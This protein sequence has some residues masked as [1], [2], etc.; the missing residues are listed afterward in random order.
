M[1]LHT[2]YYQL[3][4]KNAA[5]RWIKSGSIEVIRMIYSAVRDHNWETIEPHIMDEKIVQNDNGFEIWTCVKYHH[6]NIHFLAEYIITGKDNMLE[7]ELNGQ[8]QSSFTTCR[9]GFCVLHPLKECSGKRCKVIHPDNSIETILFPK[10]ISANQPM[11]NISGMKWEPGCNTTARLDFEGEIFE[12]ED[13]RNW[14]DASYK[15]YCR[16]LNLPFPYD[17]LKGENI[18]QK[19]VLKIAGN[20]QLKQ[21][22]PKFITFNI[23]KNRIFKIPEFGI[24]NASREEPLTAF[25]SLLLKKIPLS[26]LRCEIKLYETNWNLSLASAITNADRL[27]LPFFFVLYHSK[28]WKAELSIFFK[29]SRDIFLKVSHILIVGE[30]HMTDYSVFEAA[31]P[32]LKNRFPSAKIGTGVNAYFAELNRDRQFSTKPDFVNFT[33]SP[34]VHAFDNDSLVENLEGQKFVVE[35]AKLYFPGKSIYVSPVTLKQ[36]FN[37]VATEEE[38][39]LQAKDL[40]QQVDFRQS[41]VFAAK[42]LIGSIKFLSQAGADLITYFE[43]VGWKGFIQGDFN[44]PLPKKFPG[45]IGDVFPV[46]TIFKEICGFDKIIFSECNS[47]L[48]IDGLVLLNKNKIKAILSN[49]TDS[50]KTVAFKG[51]TFKT[52][53]TFLSGKISSINNELEIPAKELVILRN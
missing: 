51:V 13:Q 15:T 34:Q 35:S 30:N 44:P 23:D 5:V 50:P 6:N 33:I 12:M 24:C 25:E 53:E 32:M 18:H 17:I 4:Y 42:W 52:C 38:P 49:F 31:Y 9:I 11:L 8:A 37:V 46:Y 19:V 22:S 10:N 14:T 3:E 45:R 27:N 2:R 39:S 16:P 21:E 1:R 7:F 26:H 36:R 20:E 40:P 29:A 28:E 43:S 47:P 48:E 41:S